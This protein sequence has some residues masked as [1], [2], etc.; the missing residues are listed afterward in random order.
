MDSL[1]RPLRDDAV[2]A[3]TGPS[4]PARPASP[5]GRR[6][7]IGGLLRRWLG[8]RDAGT[9]EVSAPLAVPAAL[10]AAPS[11]PATPV[12]PVV[13]AEPAPTPESAAVN[14]VAVPRS[15]VGPVT[16]MVP[17]VVLTGTQDAGGD[18][19]I[20]VAE[21]VDEPLLC[22][23]RDDLSED[24]LSSRADLR[25]TLDAT[26]LS[27]LIEAYL[28]GLK[29][30]VPTQVEFPQGVLVVDTTQNL[31]YI[32]F[33]QSLWSELVSRPL[34]KRPKTRA[35]SRQEFAEMSARWA[36]RVTVARLDALLWRAGLET[37]VGRLPTGVSL[38]KPVFLKHWPNL[39][40]VHNTP[41]AMRIAA[42]WATR[43]AGL[44]ET[45]STLKVAQRHVF[46]FYNAA[47]A[48]DLITDDDTQVR[49]AQ[50]RGAKNKGLLRRLFGWLQK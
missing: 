13:A 10:A 23:T 31:A 7:G 12:A 29:W 49:R 11:L 45:V 8:G 35:I 14:P 28:V 47:L 48:L 27:A 1:L 38:Q 30:Q 44:L 46:A 6:S 15:V 50:R 41:H 36:D 24:E 19:P 18:R 25:Y 4:G 17:A 21:L 9:P 3:T 26:A 2:P 43:G 39:T 20:P 32:D 40:R 16:P 5:E 33:D 34:P 37:S 42:L 22:G